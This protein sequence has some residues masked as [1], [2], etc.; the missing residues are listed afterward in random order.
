MKELSRVIEVSSGFDV[1][2]AA[3]TIVCV[4]LMCLSLV[5]VYSLHPILIGRRCAFAEWPTAQ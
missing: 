3:V 5:V 1:D 2:A 4:V